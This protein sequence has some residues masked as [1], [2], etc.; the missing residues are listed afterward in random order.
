MQLLKSLS[1]FKQTKK[2]KNL[3]EIIQKYAK[4]DCS[5]LEG[6]ILITAK[7]FGTL[8]KMDQG[9]KS[10]SRKTPKFFSLTVFIKVGVAANMVAHKVLI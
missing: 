7:N 6:D 2:H 4:F 1:T 10:N 5:L 3:L 8:Y 9:I